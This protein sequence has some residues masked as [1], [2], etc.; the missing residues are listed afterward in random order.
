MR[1]ASFFHCG[2]NE[3]DSRGDT[4]ARAPHYVN[5]RWLPAV[6]DAAPPD[7]AI[8]HVRPAPRYNPLS[9]PLYN[10]RKGRVA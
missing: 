5:D 1:P 8:A 3:R 10:R 7:G 2:G 4:A 9:P 6:A